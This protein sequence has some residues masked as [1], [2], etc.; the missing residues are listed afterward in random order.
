MNF[1]NLINNHVAR[2]SNNRP[3]VLADHDQ[4]AGRN[5]VDLHEHVCRKQVIRINQCEQ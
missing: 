5:R 1:T 2:R 3:S 4:A